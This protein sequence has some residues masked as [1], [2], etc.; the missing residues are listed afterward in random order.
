MLSDGRE[1]S[2]L[3]ECCLWGLLTVKRVHFRSYE[4]LKYHYFLAALAKLRAT[5]AAEAVTPAMPIKDAAAKVI[6]C[7]M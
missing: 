1:S 3:V 5:M 2:F 6:K 4:C 7:F